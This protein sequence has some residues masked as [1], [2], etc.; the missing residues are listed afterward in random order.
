MTLWQSYA[1]KLNSMKNR[2]KKEGTD[3]SQYERWVAE[4]NRP[5]Y[6]FHGTNAWEVY[7][8]LYQQGFNRSFAG[9]NGE[10]GQVSTK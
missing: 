7:E 3:S 10:C 2:A 9:K 6:Y 1:A 4:E 5:Q 8:C